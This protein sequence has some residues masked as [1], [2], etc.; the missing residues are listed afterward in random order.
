M[1]WGY[2]RLMDRLVL[3]GWDGAR[4][5]PKLTKGEKLRM[6]WMALGFGRTP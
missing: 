6:A 2:K 1:M 5:R 4:P 3:R